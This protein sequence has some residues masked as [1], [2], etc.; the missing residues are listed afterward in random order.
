MDLVGDPLPV[1]YSPSANTP[2]GDNDSL[3]SDAEDVDLVG[4]PLPVGNSSLYFDKPVHPARKSR[5]GNLSSPNFPDSDSGDMHLRATE[6]DMND[7]PLYNA[8]AGAT[9]SKAKAESASSAGDKLSLRRYAQYS[10][11]VLRLP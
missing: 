10:C 4:D 7:T 1:G 11:R 5:L 6:R 3:D 8:F 2:I 9:I